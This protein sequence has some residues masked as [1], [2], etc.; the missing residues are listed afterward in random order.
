MPQNASAPPARRGPPPWLWVAGGAFILILA[1]AF[2]WQRTSPASTPSTGVIAEGAAV[3]ALSQPS[4][5]GQALS[6]AQ[7]SG[8]KVVVYFYEGAG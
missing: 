3:P 8:K 5:T 7:F 1:G 2:I 4:T 6:L